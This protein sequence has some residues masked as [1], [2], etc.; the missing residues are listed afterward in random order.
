VKERVFCKRNH[1]ETSAEKIEMVPVS[2]D[3][4]K[5]LAPKVPR[6]NSF[7][8]KGSCPLLF[9]KDFPSVATNRRTMQSGT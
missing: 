7:S 9:V 4:L 1:A 2:H 6:K 3:P 5:L 8:S